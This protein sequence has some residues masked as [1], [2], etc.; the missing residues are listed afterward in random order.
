[1]SL[2]PARMESL[3]SWSTQRARPR[4]PRSSPA[5]PHSTLE[6][7]TDLVHV[8]KGVQMKGVRFNYLVARE[9]RSRYIVGAQYGIRYGRC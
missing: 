2:S 4:L 8:T 5:D 3:R 7:F 6:C 9:N 1:M